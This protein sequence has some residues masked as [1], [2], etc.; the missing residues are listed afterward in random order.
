MTRAP[1]PTDKNAPRGLNRAAG[2]AMLSQTTTTATAAPREG[3]LW[4]RWAA[5]GSCA[6]GL[7]AIWPL[8]RV[9]ICAAVPA[10]P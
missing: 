8:V 5:G 3:G 7:Q 9:H 4:L 10:D 6:G 2:P 1:R